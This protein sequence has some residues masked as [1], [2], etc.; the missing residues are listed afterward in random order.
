M[1]TTNPKT[2]LF[3]VRLPMY[4]P[5]SSPPSLSHYTSHAGLGYT[6]LAA[7]NYFQQRG[8]NV[9]GTCRSE[10]KTETL[11]A[12]GFH[13]VFTFHTDGYQQLEYVFFLCS[14]C[15]SSNLPQLK[16]PPVPNNNNAADQHYKNSCHQPTSSLQSR[17]NPTK[18][19]TLY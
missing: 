16:L 14:V 1:A 6:G 3:L 13:D 5:Y 7:A 12:H 11:R 9:S 19:S 18:T 4:P 15:I 17:L 2:C 8:W 10:D